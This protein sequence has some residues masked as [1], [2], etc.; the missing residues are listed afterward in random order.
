MGERLASIA[1]GIVSGLPDNWGVGISGRRRRH[2]GILPFSPCLERRPPAR[3]E[4]HFRQLI[5]KFDGG[6][7]ELWL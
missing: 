4:G 7:R 1:T 5:A 3:R 2:T 6:M